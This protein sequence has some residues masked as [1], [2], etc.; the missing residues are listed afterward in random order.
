MTDA[1]ASLVKMEADGSLTTA[2]AR[3]VLKQLLESGGD[4]ESIAAALGFE[5]MGAGDLAAW[6]TGSRAS[7]HRNG[8][9]TWPA[10]TS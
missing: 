10:R 7:T 3:T 8:P 5:A 6:W 9:A 2:Q 1:F 4:P